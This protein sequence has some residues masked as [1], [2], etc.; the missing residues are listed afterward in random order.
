MNARF[1]VFLV[2]M[3]LSLGGCFPSS[4]SEVDCGKKPA[5][6]S[7]FNTTG[8]EKTMDDILKNIVKCVDDEGRAQAM[9]AN[10]AANAPQ[11][12]RDILADLYQNAAPDT[13]ALTAAGVE[14]LNIV[15]QPKDSRPKRTTLLA[16]AVRSSNYR[17]T[18]AL[19]EAGAD[20][21]G[22]GS[23]M[24]Y[25]ASD[26]IW[27][28][29]SKWSHLFQDGAPAI[30]F[31]EAYLK[32]GGNLNT[33]A[34]G[35][36][37]NKS[38]IEAPYKNL[39]AQIFLLEKG[40]DPWLTAR[41]PKPRNFDLTMMGSLIFGALSPDTNETMYVIVKKGL[42]QMPPQP[43]YRPRVH[44]HYLEALEELS[45][46]TGPERRHELWTLQRVVHAL[47]ETNAFEPSARMQ[48][49]LASNPVP[50]AEGGWVMPEG[51]LHQNYDD[52]RV[53]ATLG[54]EVW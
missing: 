30:P 7:Y 43:V 18:I 14:H 24:A 54:T 25:V 16:E 28:P 19:L 23:L 6:R 53:G 35:G 45:D 50:D 27:D 17:W 20:P 40:A 12:V 29:R 46:A 5:S 41:D 1:L 8:L 52:A 32:F 13:E 51:Q 33:T 34:S 39:A 21:N 4:V 38:L 9:A 42:F 47:I 31:L 37:G 36:A 26:N 10:T 49:L 22:S 44:G 3:C 2:A 11:V 15:L 48:E